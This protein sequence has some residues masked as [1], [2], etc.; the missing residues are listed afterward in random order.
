VKP[1]AALGVEVGDSLHEIDT[2]RTFL[3]DGAM[4]IEDLRPHVRN[5]VWDVA[6]LSWVAATGGTGTESEVE[7]TNWPALATEATLDEIRDDFN[8]VQ[9]ANAVG[10]AGA[11]ISFQT[12]FEEITGW[13]ESAGADN[14][15]TSVQ[16]R[17]AGTK[18]LSFDKIAG[19]TDAMIS[20]VCAA[21]DISEYSTHAIG[22]GHIYF[23]S[24][25]NIVKA[26]VRIGT[27]SSNY[28]QWD[29]LVS[30]LQVG[31]NETI[32]Y[33]AAPDS[34]VG[35]GYDLSAITYIA[36]GVQFS[37]AANTLAGLLC[38]GLA[39]KRVL[40]VYGMETIGTE[41]NVPFTTIKDYNGNT[42]LDV[43]SG[44][45]YN[46]LPV[47]LT[48][49]TNVYDAAKETGGNLAT[50][51]AKD[52]ATQTTLAAVLAKLTSDPATQTTLAAILAKIIAAPA[53]EA[54]QL[55]DGHNVT[56]TNTEYPL[57]AAQVT[58]LT[59]P[60]AITG[61]ATSAKQLADN[62]QVQV[63]N[64]PETQTVDGFPTE[65]PLPAAQ[66]ATLTP[67]A[68]ITNFANETGGNLA[69]ILA[70]ISSDPAT[71]TTL[72]AILAK[73]TSDPA[74][75]TTL[76]AIL[77]KQTADPSTAT[78]QTSGNASLTTIAGK[79]FATQTTL[80]AILAKII[81]AP[82][83]E[84][85]QLPNNHQVTVSNF[86]ATQ[87][88][89]GTVSV[90]EPVSVDDNG[91]SLTVDATNLDIRNLNATDDVVKVEGGNTTDVKVTLD[92]EAVN[93]V[94]KSMTSTEATANTSGNTLVKTPASG[95]KLRVYSYKYSGGSDV[96]GVLCGLRFTTTG[97]IF[98][99]ARI[100]TDGHAF[101]HNVAGGNGY[102]EGGVDESLYVNLGAAQ[103]VYAG[104]EVIEV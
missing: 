4:W 18:S 38:G 50:L 86:P 23:S 6:S 73:L 87:P 16:H 44:A 9:S 77:A 98:G 7:V 60:A 45:N 63:S 17:G 58:T 12:L 99:T 34:Q 61:F 89:S 94:D 69:A 5:Y 64:F 32:E 102:I 100:V 13:T 96:T 31:W 26:Y 97:T 62:H 56:V 8:F 101:A 11:K 75:Q 72:A 22:T 57:P 33:I 25:T 71:Q 3:Y 82:A 27:D 46:H 103:T 80:A 93:T 1:T 92:S 81:A 43:V 91:G 28:C 39:I 10:V 29:F 20:N 88:I 66:V 53:T 14:L 74:T 51:A 21:V 36:Y 55:P 41:I 48:D 30:N 49:G 47:R 37:N 2:G 78:L 40:E 95:K 83:T 104:A 79:D 19:N 65:Y 90:T 35:N 84:A 59:P 54:K 15:A 42:R 67:P 24:L 70:K 85:K 76:A 52:F 68:A